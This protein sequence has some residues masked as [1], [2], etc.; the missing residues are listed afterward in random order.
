[1]RPIKPMFDTLPFLQ[2]WID[3]KLQETINKLNGS[4]SPPPPPSGFICPLNGS[5]KSLTMTLVS[6]LLLQLQVSLKWS[7]DASGTLLCR[8][9]LGLVGGNN[10][11]NYNSSNNNNNENT[12][13]SNNSYNN[14]S[15]QYKLAS[16][17]AS[18]SNIDENN[19]IYLQPESGINHHKC[20]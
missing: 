4:L 11:N 14:I 12:Y 10:N 15:S 5:L 13:R 6:I 8:Q 7:G 1:M 3:L 20:M 2:T 16:S 17:S 9:R 18:K 19:F